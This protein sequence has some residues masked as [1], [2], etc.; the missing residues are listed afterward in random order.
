MRER[1]PV[2]LVTG[3]ASGIGAA[4]ARRLARA[5]T[6]VALLDRDAIGLARTTTML[7]DAPHG[8]VVVDVRERGEVEAAVAAMERDMGPIAGLVN[9]A[10]VVH[11]GP[12]D[13]LDGGG[14][15][16]CLAVNAG[17]VRNVSAA[18]ARHMRVRGQGAIVTVA[19]N[20]ART[21]RVDMAAY[22]AS[23][24]AA[25]AYTRCLG[26]ELA[27][28]GIRCNIVSPGST[29][30]PMQRALWRDAP[31]A[32]AATERVI[33]GDAARFKLGIPLGR[34]AQPEDVAEAVCFLLSPAARHITL[35]QLVVDGGATF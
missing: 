30:T 20:A 16:Q 17:G 26:L 32:T 33:R 11:L 27:S 29:D 1:A 12:A 5:G 18:V 24:A 28:V 34:I 14:F 2:T 4:V 3:A 8:A 13:E 19:S 21:P 9:A 22:A 25:V 15:D 10:G 23:K 35:Q 7:T 31:S 6:R